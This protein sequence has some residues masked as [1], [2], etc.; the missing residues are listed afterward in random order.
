M[1]KILNFI[2]TFSVGLAEVQL[3]DLSGPWH[4]RQYLE[5][6]LTVDLG[7]ADAELKESAKRLEV[8]ELACGVSAVGRE[9]CRR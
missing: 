1:R 6:I 4:G 9:A 7:A 5:G 2:R 8:F 3:P